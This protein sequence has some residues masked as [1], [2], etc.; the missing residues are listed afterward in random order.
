MGLQ[1]L[2]VFGQPCSAESDHTADSE[3]DETPTGLHLGQTMSC[4]VTVYVIYMW[5][6]SIATGQCGEHEHEMQKMHV[7]HMCHVHGTADRLQ[8][9]YLKRRW[10]TEPAGPIL[11]LGLRAPGLASL[12]LNASTQE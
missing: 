6:L 11:A 1:G 5:Y 8:H 3:S 4:H 7:Q 2:L 9:I 12:Q 10:Q